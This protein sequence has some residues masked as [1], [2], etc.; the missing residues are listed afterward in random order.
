MSVQNRADI[1][2]VP[3]IRSGDTFSKEAET[4]AQDAGRVAVL[5]PYT[6]MAKVAAT[7][8]WVP[9][10]DE[11][12]TDGSAIPAGIYLGDEIA[13]ATIAA[14]DVENAPILV[15]GSC[16]IDQNQLVIEN[17]KLLTTVINATGGA[18]NIFIQTVVDYLEQR[19]IFVEDTVDI[20]GF[21][22]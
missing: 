2:N 3:F 17:S 14:G 7:G 16:T 1:T 12:A 8:K 4:I 5:A 13:A 21:E 22:N 11:T 19:G 15:G 10:S 18:D 20:D 9:F 6:L